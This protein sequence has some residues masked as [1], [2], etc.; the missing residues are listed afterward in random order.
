MKNKSGDIHTRVGINAGK[1]S[2]L[3]FPRF[4]RMCYEEDIKTLGESYFRRGHQIPSL[5]ICVKHN[6]FLEDLHV[7]VNLLNKHYFVPA[8]IIENNPIREIRINEKLKVK[9]ISERACELLKVGSPHIYTN[10]AYFYSRKIKELGF[11]K[12]QKAIDLSSLYESFENHFSPHVLSIFRSQVDY[13]DPN[14]WLKSMVRKHRKSIDPIR[15]ILI[16]NFILTLGNKSATTKS[17]AKKWPCLNPICE[18]YN[19]KVIRKHQS[20]VDRKSGR[21][22]KFIECSCGY[23]YTESYL[24]NK[25]VFF[26]RVKNHGALWERELKELLSKGLSVR[27]IAKIL[28]SDSKTIKAILNKDLTNTKNDISLNEKKK[29][30]LDL[31]KQN[32]QLSI[33]EL[34]KLNMALYSSI[35]RRDNKWLL[36]QKYPNKKL[37]IKQRVDWAKRDSEYLLQI[38]EKIHYLKI[39]GFNKRLTKTMLISLINKQAIIEKNYPKL[40]LTMDYLKKV[41]ESKETY[42][43]RR[44]KN[45]QT[46]LISNYIDVTRWRLLRE[47]GI[48]EEYLSPKI[49]KVVDEL[50]NSKEVKDKNLLSA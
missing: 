43:I 20:S 3:Q 38:K 46:R 37:P 40:P 14:C 22:I 45:A 24:E 12:N 15:H 50:L 29:Q 33:T 2:P 19:K 39:T 28:N 42:R 31:I 17:K 13:N 5:P 35:Y 47:A 16:E 25:K 7:G 30:W 8:S 9:E 18:H 23:G 27:K 48:R 34:R 32:S 1:F 26:R 11:I 6:V 21:E 10:H 41:I 36:K 49:E 44:L 4:C